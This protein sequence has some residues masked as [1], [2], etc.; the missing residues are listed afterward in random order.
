[1]HAAAFSMRLARICPGP[2][3]AC[4]LGLD[5][6]SAHLGIVHERLEFRIELAILH[7]DW[8]S[9]IVGSVRL[10]FGNQVELAEHL[11]RSIRKL[12]IR[13]RGCVQ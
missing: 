9:H 7:V 1:M 6:D 2:I 8:Q 11:A 5:H 12:K 4:S 10:D 13:C 3:T